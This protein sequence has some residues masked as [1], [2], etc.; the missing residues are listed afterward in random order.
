MA[1]LPRGFATIDP[2]DG[3]RCLGG[4]GWCLPM[5][6]PWQPVKGGCMLCLYPGKGQ[7]LNVSPWGFDYNV[8]L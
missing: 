1:L 8:P 5:Q 3:S 4:C 6:G 2:V 7:G